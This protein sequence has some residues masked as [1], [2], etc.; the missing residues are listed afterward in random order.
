MAE[1]LEKIPDEAA[2]LKSTFSSFFDSVFE[3]FSSKKELRQED[4]ELLKNTYS[5]WASAYEKEN[6]KSVGAGEIPVYN[7]NNHNGSYYYWAEEQ[8]KGRAP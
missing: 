3:F 8:R 4:C 5:V 6:E 1:C 2:S 7:V